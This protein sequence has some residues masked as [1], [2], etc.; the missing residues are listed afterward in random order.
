MLLK[1]T[2]IIFSLSYLAVGI[3]FAIFVAYKKYKY[4]KMLPFGLVFIGLYPLIIYGYFMQLPWSLALIG[5]AIAV[6]LFFLYFKLLI[7]L[8]NKNMPSKDMPSKK[9][10]KEKVQGQRQKKSRKR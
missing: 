1:Q 10:K 7:R 5:S 2:I 9:E 4:E 6:V 8:R 3:A